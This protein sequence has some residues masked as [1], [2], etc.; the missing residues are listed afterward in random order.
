MVSL[1]KPFEGAGKSLAGDAAV[2]MFGVESKDV[3][4]LVAFGLE[5]GVHALIGHNPIVQRGFVAI[6]AVV[7]LADFEPETNGPGVALR[8]QMLVIF[9]GAV[10]RFGAEGRLLIDVSARIGQDAMVE[11]GMIPSH[12]ERGGPAGTA[13][14]CGAAIGV[15]G[16]GDV[17]VP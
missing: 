8:D 14:H 15:F 16:E 11:I 3:A 17:V 9:P 4:V 12:G 6:I 13:A 7:V 5:D 10:R 1:P 2:G